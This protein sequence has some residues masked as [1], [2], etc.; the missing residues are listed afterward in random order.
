MKL[1]IILLLPLLAV[2]VIDWNTKQLE[3]TSQYQFEITESDKQTQIKKFE[4]EMKRMES[5]FNY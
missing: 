1:I 5:Y 2:G 3:E 4:D